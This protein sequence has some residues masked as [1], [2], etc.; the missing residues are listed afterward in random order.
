MIHARLNDFITEHNILENSQYGFRKKHSTSL[1]I[2][3]LHETIIEGLE[4]KKVSVALFIDLKSAFDTINHFILIKKLDHYGIRGKA[5]ELISSYLKGRKQFVKGDDV[6]SMILNVLCGVPQ[7]S[8]LGPLLFIIYI[9]DIVICSSELTALL[10]ADDA[11]LILSHESIKQIE[12]N[13]IVK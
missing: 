12:K 1:G 4:K 6:E 11:V 5:L 2:T 13:S 9:N 10:F 8:V 3:H 7:G